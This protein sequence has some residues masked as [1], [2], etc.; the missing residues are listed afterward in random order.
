MTARL[1]RIH[2]MLRD[3]NVPSAISHRPGIGTVLH[4]GTPEHGPWDVLL[5]DAGNGL[6]LHHAGGTDELAAD[7]TDSLVVDAVRIRVVQ[8]WADRGN[9]EAR[10]LIAKLHHRSQHD[11]PHSGEHT[12][13]RRH[14]DSP[15]PT[16]LF[17]PLL[18]DPLQFASDIFQASNRA[19]WAML[20][21]GPMSAAFTWSGPLGTYLGVH[22][23]R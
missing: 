2:A 12:G 8:A 5:R 9:P 7:S 11:Q 1:Q 10:A 18:F 15:T 6:L 3:G 20:T 4:A 16:L 21:G 19:G 17:D 23:K 13:A 14:H 22:V